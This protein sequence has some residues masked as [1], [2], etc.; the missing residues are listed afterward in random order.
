MDAWEIWN[1]GKPLE[2]AHLHF[3]PQD[4]IKALRDHAEE[5]SA[6]QMLGRLQTNL[7]SGKD[8]FSA[9]RGAANSEKINAQTKLRDE[10]RQAI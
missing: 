2:R 5:N 4:K 6:S 8:F 10:V 3:G 7:E 9:L 1:I